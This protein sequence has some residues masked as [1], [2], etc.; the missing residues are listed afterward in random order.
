MYFNSRS[1]AFFSANYLAAEGK[2]GLPSFSQ[3]IER[4]N[5][6]WENPEERDVLVRQAHKILEIASFIERCARK[7]MLEEGILR[8]QSRPYI[9]ISIPIMEE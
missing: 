6:M 1:S 2:L 9:M 7:E 8:K 3:T 4:L 5:L